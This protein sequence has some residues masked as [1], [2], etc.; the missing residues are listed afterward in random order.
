MIWPDRD[1]VGQKAAEKIAKRL[2]VELNLQSVKLVA[3]PDTLEEG[4]DLADEIPEGMDVRALVADAPEFEV[5]DNRI[6][7]AS[8]AD[9]DPDH[10]TALNQ[11]VAGEAGGHGRR[12]ANILIDLAQ[13]AKLFHTPD[14]NGFADLEV[15][16]HRETWPIRSE[17]F[18]LWLT[19]L[20]YKAIGGAPGSE[21]LQTAMNG[22]EAKARFDGPERKVHVRVGSLDDRLYLDLCDDVWRA[23]EI[24]ANGWRVVDNPPIRFRRFSSMKP[25]P[26]PALDG[27]IELLRPF[28]N[29]QSE[30][31]FVL[32]VAWALA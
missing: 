5:M 3:I 31:D 30:A 25:I 28:L 10:P 6:A 24:D 7:C 15:N 8:E 13:P 23:V 32:V 16:G 4:W 29:V 9:E 14:G 20:F 11:A 1:E 19:L 27:S 22:L 12:Q 21:A 18:R 26:A 2:L 17:G